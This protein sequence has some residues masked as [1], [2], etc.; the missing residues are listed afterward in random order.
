MKRKGF[1]LIELLVVIAIIGILAAIL[2]PALARAREAARRAS[3][4]NNLKQLGLVCKMYSNESKGEK[5]PDVNIKNVLPPNGNADYS[6]VKL[7]FGPYVV[8]IYPEYLTDATV[9]MCPSD[10]DATPDNY[11]AK[12]GT[13]LFHRTD[14]AGGVP[15]AASGRGCNHGGT[16]MNAVDQSYGYTGYIW[17]RVDNDDPSIAISGGALP[18]LAALF[19]PLPTPGPAQAMHWLNSIVFG[20]LSAG[21]TGGAQ[22]LAQANAM[23]ALTEKDVAVPSPNGTGGGSSVLHLRE[24]IERFMITDINNA[25]ASSKAQSQIF[26]MWDRIS[27]TPADFNHVPGGSNILYLDGH[28]SFAKYPAEQ[29]PV[30]G[31]FAAFD[32]L[33]NEGG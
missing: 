3:C 8:Q 18:G 30:Q 27:T 13:N 25:G 22:T 6:S 19:G 4:Q 28:V 14:Y 24:G 2:L 9:F 16:C 7:N 1:T 10:P 5:L 15:V 11:T 29:A 31:N 17:D 23:N 32:A 12:D 21:Y 20:I 33:V 26:I